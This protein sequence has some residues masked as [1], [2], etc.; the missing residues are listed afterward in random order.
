MY[1]ISQICVWY[2]LRL[3]KFFE[4]ILSTHVNFLKLSD[5]PS[6]FQSKNVSLYFIFTLNILKTKETFYLF[7][8]TF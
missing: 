4:T 5:T 3:F 2:L 7:C 8:I 6:S 1:V